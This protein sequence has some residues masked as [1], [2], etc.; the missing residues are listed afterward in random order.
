MRI[1]HTLELVAPDDRG[2]VAAVG[3]FDGVHLGHQKVLAEAAGIARDRG[4]TFAVLTFEPHPRMLF[5]PESVPFRLT[6]SAT[7]TAMFRHLGVELLFEQP[8]DQAFSQLSAEAFVTD[9]V[10]DGLGV[11]HVVCGY[12]FVFGH[13]RRGT[14]EMLE[15]LG[16]DAGIGVTCVPAVSEGDGAV[17]SSTRVRQCLAEG[18]PAGAAELLGRPWSFRAPVEEGDRRGRT[19]GFPTCNLRI[20]DLQQPAYGVYAVRVDLD[21]TLAAGVA[22]FGRRPTV[23]DR[24]AL[25]EVH[26]F[27]IDRDLYGRELEVHLIDFIRPEMRFSGLDEL[28]ARIAADADAARSRLSE[29]IGPLPAGAN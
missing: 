16:R 17:Y 25:F 28:K 26:L 6:S 9:V 19:I 4:L 12:D 7:R 5:Q 1:L 11:C 8:F 23:N 13:R 3:N 24:G 2:A 15:H 18:D 10:R 27:D 22:N 29:H 20:V 14:P 21:G